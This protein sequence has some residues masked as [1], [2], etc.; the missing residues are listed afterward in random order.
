MNNGKIC[1]SVCAETASGMI[2]NIR[3]AEEFADVVE[4]RFDCLASD[5]IG[6]LR[7][8][9][10]NLKFEKPLLATFRSPK[11][12][13]NGSATFEERM[14]FWGEDNQAFWA[15]DIEEDI[16]GTSRDTTRRIASFHDFS[17]VPEDI[18]GIFERLA[19]TEAEIVKIAVTAEDITDAISVWNLIERANKIGKQMIPIAMGEAGK[20]TRILGLA[21]GA[22]WTYAS[23]GTGVE[24]APG[25]V[26]AKDMRELFRVRDLD[27]NTKVFGI[28]GD[29]VS[30]SLSPAM[31]NPVF[32]SH[33]LNAVYLPLMVKDL[34]QFMRRMVRRET[35]EV[36]LNFGGFSV[37]MPHKHSIM[38][39][40][41]AIDR[42]AK[43]I[44]AVNT[45]KIDGDRLTGYNTDAHGFISPLK[46]HFGDLKGSRVAI[47]GAGGS[48]RACVFALRQE[49][50]EV[51][52][53]VR[54]TAKARSFS[55]EFQV[56]VVPISNFKYEISD[57]RNEVQNQKPKAKNQQPKTN[58]SEFD[59]VVDTTPLGMVGP[60][61]NASLFT[62][63]EL[64]GVKFVYD[65]VTK[66]R[67]TPI[68]AEAKK[69]GIPAIDGVEM[70][71]AQGA[72]QFE[73][74]TG[75]K[76]PVDEMKRT[77]VERIRELQK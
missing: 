39:H 51:E 18:D 59:I 56:P 50:A 25:Q 62:A 10:S 69:A 22:L 24:T 46:K 38:K 8:E 70:L 65:L 21:H 11:E 14:A 71:V 19:A 26:K 77:V 63:D 23:L 44:G 43:K 3:R 6:N 42:V 37:T 36:E 53:L 33:N 4:V 1:V 32:A 28:I 41:D 74:W 64:K 58:L 29:P 49:G 7:S 15:C 54:D 30:R 16:A 2:E 75:Q 55:D 52:V 35:R 40:L 61:D 66:A 9:I 12:G 20:W 45:V 5:Q 47:C 68:V 60:N 72:K 31:L 17:G 48:A 34:D 67:D 73:I 13:G 76:A 57:L 27:Q